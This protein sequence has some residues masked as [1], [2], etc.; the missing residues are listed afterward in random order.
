MKDS[1]V[2]VVKNVSDFLTFLQIIILNN[3]KNY[4]L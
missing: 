1:G 4:I 3:W 2:F